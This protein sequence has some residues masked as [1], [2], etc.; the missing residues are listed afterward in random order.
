MTAISRRDFLKYAG[1]G[2]ISVLSQIVPSRAVKEAFAEE[3]RE[4]KFN[5][6]ISTVNLGTGRSFKAWTYNDEVPGPEIRVREGET[7]RVVLRN[8]LPEGTTIHW[9]GLPVPNKMDGVPDV[10]QKPVQ[11]G[12]SFVYE[13]KAVPSGTYVYRRLV[14]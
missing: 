3:A 11:T 13:F 6:S 2:G 9:H 4:Y 10:T 5:A 8:Y 12:Q 14:P 1:I 7:L